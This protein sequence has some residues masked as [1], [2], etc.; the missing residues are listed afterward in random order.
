MGRIVGSIL[1]VNRH[2]KISQRLR[3]YIKNSRK[4][5]PPLRKGFLI[6]KRR[7]RRMPRKRLVRRAERRQLEKSVEKPVVLSKEDKP[8]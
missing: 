5:L 1:I 4:N 6:K 3:N 8:L 2:R 7:I